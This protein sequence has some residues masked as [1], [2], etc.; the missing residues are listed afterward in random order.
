MN[1]LSLEHIDKKYGDHVIFSFEKWSLD[2]GIYWVKGGNGTGKTT[3]FKVISGQTPFGGELSLN[4]VSLKKAPVAYRS[5]ISY[6]EAEPQY[7]SF[8]T[9]NELLNYHIA[10]RKAE[11]SEAQDIVEQFGMTAFMDHKIGSYSS[12]M[13]KK[14]SLIC[15]FTGNIQLYILDEPLITIDTHAAQVLYALIRSYHEK[16]SSFLLSSHQELEPGQLPLK[17]VFQIKD[18]QI[19][20]C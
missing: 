2:H 17:G 9:G 5:M 19:E 12:G 8:I 16:G 4:G 7:P 1:G 14:L 11:H 6:A 10:V 13:L 18:K 20:A 15:A 3:L